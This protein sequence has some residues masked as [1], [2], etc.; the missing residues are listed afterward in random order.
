M[1]THE[2]TKPN[3]LTCF[4]IGPPPWMND[5][6][7]RV[8]K[9]TK[10]FP[11]CTIIEIYILFGVGALFWTIRRKTKDLC[12]F[13]Q[14]ISIY[15]I[16]YIKYWEPSN[17]KN[18]GWRRRVHYKYC[19]ELLHVL[20]TPMRIMEVKWRFS[21]NCDIGVL[22]VTFLFF[23]GKWEHIGILSTVIYI[24]EKLIAYLELL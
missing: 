22:Y 10:Y 4:R 18:G 8:I 1:T 19:G 5:N 21:K 2:R 3:R 17:I 15:M 7:Y 12:F 11:V 13:C 16:A 20:V 23:I 14:K 9:W 24:S 6:P